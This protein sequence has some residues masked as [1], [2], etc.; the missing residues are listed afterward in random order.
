MEFIKSR[1]K[2]LL[3]RHRF[4]IID[5]AD[6]TTNDVAYNKKCTLECQKCGWIRRVSIRRAL[7]LLVLSTR[8][9]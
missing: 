6:P 9:E 5:V 3:C 2:I 1:L 8:D 4:C 7:F